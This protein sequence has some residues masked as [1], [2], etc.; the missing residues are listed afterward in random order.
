MYSIRSGEDRSFEEGVLEQISKAC[1]IHVFSIG[2]PSIPGHG[3]QTWSLDSSGAESDISVS[4]AQHLPTVLSQLNH[5][6]KHMQVDIL[7]VDCKECG[8]LVVDAC[9][10]T[11]S[12]GLEV[13][14]ILLTFRFDQASLGH[15]DEVMLKQFFQFLTSK[16]YHAFHQVS[17]APNHVEISLLKLRKRAEPWCGPGKY[18]ND[19]VFRCPI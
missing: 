12:A 19:A 10:R 16:G 6:G 1:D 11:L 5:A 13:R 3:Y 4:F 14:Q 18:C 15:N 7:N 17:T 9:R 8:I 2:T